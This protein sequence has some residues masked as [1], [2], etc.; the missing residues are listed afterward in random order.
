MQCLL[1]LNYLNELNDIVTNNWDQYQE[2]DLAKNFLKLA[3]LLNQRCDARNIEAQE[4]CFYNIKIRME[5]FDNE[6]YHNNQCDAYEFLIDFC[7]CIDSEIAAH[8]SNKTQFL[9]DKFIIQYHKHNFKTSPL[10]PITDF[11]LRIQ[12]IKSNSMN[13]ALTEADITITK[14]PE[15]LLIK[16]NQCN[17]WLMDIDTPLDLSKFIDTALSDSCVYIIQSVVNYM[18]NRRSGHYWGYFQSIMI[19]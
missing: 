6:Y 9:K 14:L 17:E 5:E 12:S 4:L 1:K 19:I 16:L 7:E 13:D 2:E 18:G 10:Q 3:K 8:H 11:G 15:I